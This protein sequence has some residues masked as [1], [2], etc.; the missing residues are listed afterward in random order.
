[1]KYEHITKMENILNEHEE[2]LSQLE[3]I[4]TYLEETIVN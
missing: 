2:K 1:M 3:E 4:L